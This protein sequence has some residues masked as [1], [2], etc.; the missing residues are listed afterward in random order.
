MLDYTPK[1]ITQLIAAGLLT[2]GLSTAVGC[3]VEVEDE[4]EMPE[5]QVEGGEMPEYDVDTAE[6][7]VGTTETTMEV[8]D[9]D[10]HM[11]EEAVEVPTIG[12]DPANAEQPESQQ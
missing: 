9:V 1:I 3:D 12:I 7:E 11:E 8:P 5:V 6:L 10:V 4:G 2:V